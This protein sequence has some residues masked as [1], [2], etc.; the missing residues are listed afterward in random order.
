MK[1]SVICC[2]SACLLILSACSKLPNSVGRPRDVVVIASSV[3][4]ATIN[5][6][7]QIVNYFPQPEPMFIFIF[8]ADTAGHGVKTFN[9]L[10]LYGSLEDKFISTMLNPDARA[11]AKRDTFTLFL[12]HDL[13]ARPQTAVIMAASTPQYVVPGLYRYREKIRS[14]LEENYYAQLK[15]RYYEQAIDENIKRSTVRF[16]FTVDVHEGWLVD[17]THWEKGFVSVHAH[18]PDRSVFFYREKLTQSLSDSF[19]VKKRDLLTGLYYNGD[20]ILKDLT[21]IEPVEFK[22]MRGYRIKGVWQNDSLVAGGPFLSYA[23]TDNQILYFIDGLLFSPGER[24]TDY[25]LTLEIIMNSI[26][27]TP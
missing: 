5:R 18:Y 23:L 11:A 10:F 21:W 13:W 25:Y 3:D 26:E 22:S 2:L 17:S 15:S 19:V 1:K 6:T 9:T 12:I 8:A 14:L 20:H 27:I 16:G 7:I 4:T 24:K